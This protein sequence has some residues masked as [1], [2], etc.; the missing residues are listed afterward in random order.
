M[1]F[2]VLYWRND[3]LLLSLL[4]KLYLRGGFNSCSAAIEIG[5]AHECNLSDLIQPSSLI[6]RPPPAAVCRWRFYMCT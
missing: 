3:A 1:L 5:R 2:L 4:I 6:G